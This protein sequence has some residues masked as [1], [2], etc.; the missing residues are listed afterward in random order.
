MKYLELEE[1]AKRGELEIHKYNVGNFFRKRYIYSNEPDILD[2][3]LISIKK[4]PYKRYYYSAR[5]KEM[6]EHQ[7]Y[8]ITAKDYK[9]LL[10][11]GARITS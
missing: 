2:Q 10:L 6:P 1:K 8:K 11:V 9:N 3:K 5:T 4:A 7:S